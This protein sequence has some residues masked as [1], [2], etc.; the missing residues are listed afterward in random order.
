M[1]HGGPLILLRLEGLAILTAG[2]AAFLWLGQSAWLFAALFLV[3]DVSFAAYLVGPRAGAIAYNSLHSTIGP[4]L[5]A[6]FGFF[7]SNLFFETVAAIW[8]AHIGFDRALGYGLKYAS[9]FHETHLGRIG[10]QA[11]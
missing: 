8:L 2:V 10:R 9:G 5:M 4:L 1:I 3:P 6:G 11:K 7:W